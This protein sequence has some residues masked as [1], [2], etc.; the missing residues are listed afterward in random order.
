MDNEITLKL[1]EKFYLDSLR[2]IWCKDQAQEWK[3][4]GCPYTVDRGE[5]RFHCYAYTKKMRWVDMI[6]DKNTLLFIGIVPH[7]GE[8]KTVKREYVDKIILPCIVFITEME[9]HGYLGIVVSKEE[10]SDDV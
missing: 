2:H 7:I 1:T 8:G 3:D 5:I 6:F 9:V 10:T 4:M